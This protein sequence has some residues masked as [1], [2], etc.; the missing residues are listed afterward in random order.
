MHDL[1][2]AK[3]KKWDNVISPFTIWN[4]C[5]SEILEAD[6]VI[7]SSLHGLI[8]A[9]AYGIP[10]RYIRISETENL[11]KYNDYMMGTGRNEIDYARDIGEAIE[12]G[13][14]RPPVFDA[15]KLLQTFPID[16]WK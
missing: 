11:F 6:L 10:A 4:N 3:E 14:M 2:T 13:G 5:I 16:L 8:I 15:V 7:A 1:Q 9:E 12:M